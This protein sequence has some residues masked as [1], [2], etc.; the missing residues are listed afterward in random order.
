MLTDFKS[1]YHQIKMHP[2]TYRFLGIE[3][4]GQVYCFTHLPFG[5]SSAC[6]AYTILMG[7]VYRP[8]RENGQNMTY[9]IDDALYAFK[10]QVQGQYQ[11]RTILMVLTALGFFLSI[12]KCQLQLGTTG[13][14][15][16]LIVNT[17]QLRFEI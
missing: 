4:E 15:L 3:F 13:R 10:D 1:G 5:L 11:A 17:T 2:N 8:F 14:F 9:L 7:E 16:G 6:R 12:K